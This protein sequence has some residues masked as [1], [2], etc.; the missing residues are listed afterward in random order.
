MRLSSDTAAKISTITVVAIV[1]LGAIVSVAG[2]MF[3]IGGQTGGSYKV[4]ISV[5]T[6]DIAADSGSVYNVCTKTPSGDRYYDP[7]FK[8]FILHSPS[9]KAILYMSATLGS[10]TNYSGDSDLRTVQTGTV[11]LSSGTITDN[12]F[13][14]T[15]RT[16]DSEM[17]ASVFLLLKGYT[18]DASNGTVVDI[19][20]NSP[21]E[22]GIILNIDMKEHSRTYSLHGN[23]SSNLRGLLEFT[24]TVESV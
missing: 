6:M 8:D 10:R 19:Y 15:V 17:T 23:P 18:N 5:E 14:F 22:S 16:S 2:M 21:G 4:T 11:P 13:G 1:F 20:E 3:L 24:V 12:T 7:T 9:D